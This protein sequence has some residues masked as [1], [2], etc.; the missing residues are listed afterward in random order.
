M[1]LYMLE[2][3]VQRKRFLFVPLSRRT[4]CV[5]VSCFA[6]SKNL[7]GKL[8]LVLYPFYPAVGSYLSIVSSI[9][10]ASSDVEAKPDRQRLFIICL[11]FNTHDK[12]DSTHTP[13]GLSSL[14]RFCQKK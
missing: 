9:K 6:Y 4:Y 1:Y 2:A 7:R 8:L 5:V 14:S 13:S 11:P 3:L 12:T 10:Q